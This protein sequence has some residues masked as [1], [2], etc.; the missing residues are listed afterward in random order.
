MLEEIQLNKITPEKFGAF[1]KVMDEF[2][3]E[4]YLNS[5]QVS[6][7]TAW[8]PDKKYRLVIDVIQKSQEIDPNRVVRARFKIISYKILKK[9]SIDEMNDVE[10]GE[11]QGQQLEAANTERQTSPSLN[12]R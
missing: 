6:E 1:D 10:F 4:L 9:K 7:I 5:D 3:P 8:E 2:L 12:E 11:Y